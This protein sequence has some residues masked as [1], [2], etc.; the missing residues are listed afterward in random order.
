[1]QLSFCKYFCY[2]TAMNTG[3]L[4]STCPMNYVIELVGDKWSLLIIRDIIFDNKSSYGDFLASEEKIATNILASRLALLEK[5]G[6]ILKLSNPANKARPTYVLT[7]LAIDLVPLFV[8]MILWSEKH[9]PHPIPPR[10][11]N[12]LRAIHANKVAFI[13]NAQEELTARVRDAAGVLG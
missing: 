10:R 2:N 5:E 13:H 11:Q 3:E 1:M 6:F 8:E 7:Q 9:G 12:E 4:R